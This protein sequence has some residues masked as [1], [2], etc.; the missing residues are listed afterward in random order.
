MTLS[1]LS[2]KNTILFV[3]YRITPSNMA[4]ELIVTYLYI[5]KM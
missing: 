2:F 5:D 3:S 1:D 4:L